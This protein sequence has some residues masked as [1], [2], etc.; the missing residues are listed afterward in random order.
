MFNTNVSNET[1]VAVAVNISSPQDP[2]AAR[3]F[4]EMRRTVISDIVHAATLK[5]CE[6]DV[7]VI[8]L[9]F[10]GP[11]NGHEVHFGFTINGKKI[12]GTTNI[13]DPNYWDDALAGGKLY[14]RILKVVSEKIA[15]EAEG[16]ICREIRSKGGRL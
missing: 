15:E 9:C 12:L 8:A 6:V 11:F 2:D 1:N 4:N 3:L 13:L 10:N 7:N 14:H 5:V 16:S